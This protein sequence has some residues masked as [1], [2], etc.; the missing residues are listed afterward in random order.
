MSFQRQH[1][2]DRDR[3]D[4]A[5]DWEAEARARGIAWEQAR[6]LYEEAVYRVHGS[7][8]GPI[9]ESVEAVYLDLLDYAVAR[10]QRVPGRRSKIQRLLDRS[11]GARPAATIPGRVT[12]IEKA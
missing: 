3:R 12:R 7:G 1:R 11:A 8:Y 10:T 2:S 6:A 9:A 4:D 5:F